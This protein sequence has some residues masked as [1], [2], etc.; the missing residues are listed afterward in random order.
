M[1]WIAAAVIG[2]NLVSGYLGSK[3]SQNAAQ[4]QADAANQ[5]SDN[6]LAM[7]NTINNQQAPGRATGYTAL[8]QIGALNNGQYTQYDAN[9]N[10]IG[11]AT[12]SGYLT[13]QFNNQDLN[14]NL[15][16]NYA[17]QLQQGQ[18]ATNQANN[19]T[20]GMVSG[21]A[22]KGL[23]DYTQGAAGSAYQQAFNNY[24]SQRTGI[25]NTLASIAGLGQTANAQSAQAGT[26]YANAA[27]QLGVGSAAAQAAGQIGSTQALTG[28]I[29]GASNGFMLS[30]LLSPNTGQNYAGYGGADS[31]G[32][33]NIPT[34]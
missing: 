34:Y 33:L 24:T 3:A 14:A 2:S 20:G 21:N 19:A 17:F 25:Y 18:N 32:N 16:P 6:Q 1:S 8:N 26:N 30:K 22:L 29:T 7:F 23:Q 4:M 12:G 28:G 10:P 11:T 9:G 13:N 31:V 15:A 5:A 27:S